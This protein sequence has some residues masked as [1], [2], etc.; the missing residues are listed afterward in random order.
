MFIKNKELIELDE[1]LFKI[2]NLNEKLVKEME[3]WKILKER[4]YSTSLSNF[5][6]SHVKDDNSYFLN[7]DLH[8]YLWTYHNWF[9]MIDF[10]ELISFENKYLEKI[11]NYI[12]KSTKTKLELFAKETKFNIVQNIEMLW[13]LDWMKKRFVIRNILKN[14]EIEI[15][16]LL[17]EFNEIEEFNTFSENEKKIYLTNF[18]LYLLFKD[19]KKNEK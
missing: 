1:F 19:S 15:I 17:K 6:S 5:L 9:K 18:L 11:N 4:I 10:E 12:E 13:K 8:N 2:K 16:D 7:N 3:I 14:I